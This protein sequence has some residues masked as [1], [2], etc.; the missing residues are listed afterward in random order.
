MTEIKV[1]QVWKVRAAP[2]LTVRVLRFGDGIVYY[3]RDTGTLDRQAE[4]V[5]RYCFVPP[6]GAQPSV[7]P[8]AHSPICDCGAL[9]AK[10]THANWCSTGGAR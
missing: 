2:D 7:V 6:L 5:F 1:G 10:T 4:K 3:M 9:K 8:P